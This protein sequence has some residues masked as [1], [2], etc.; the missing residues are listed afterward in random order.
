MLDH[1]SKKSRNTSAPACAAE[2]LSSGVVDEVARSAVS[3]TL[4][5]LSAASFSAR[6]A[7][8]P[9]ILRDS[10]GSKANDRA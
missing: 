4:V 7:E 5:K 2:L 8:F 6:S 10:S 9:R 3:S 1:I